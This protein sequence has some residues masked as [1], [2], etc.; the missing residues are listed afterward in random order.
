METSK[1][2]CEH[3]FLKYIFFSFLYHLVFFFNGWFLVLL[4]VCF[5]FPPFIVSSGVACQAKWA[6]Q[7]QWVRAVLRQKAPPATEVSG[8]RSGTTWILWQYLRF[9]FLHGNILPSKVFSP[10]ARLQSCCFVFPPHISP[11][12]WS[13]NNKLVLPG[14]CYWL[15]ILVI[16]LN[17]ICQDQ[18]LHL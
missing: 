2:K 12:T 4:F 15:E 14:S 5:L 13:A 18:S 7:A 16:K 10:T 3:L 1:R 6:E 9:P 11:C 17:K 8:W